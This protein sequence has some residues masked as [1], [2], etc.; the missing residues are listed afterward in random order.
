MVR[1]PKVLNLIEIN[2]HSDLLIDLYLEYSLNKNKLIVSY[3]LRFF[4]R[5]FYF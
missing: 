4:I 5:Y 2:F 3:Y 1:I